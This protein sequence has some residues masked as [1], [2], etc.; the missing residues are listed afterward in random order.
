MSIGLAFVPARVCLAHRERASAMVVRSGVVVVL[1][2]APCLARTAN[3][4]LTFSLDTA[5]VRYFTNSNS[6]PGFVSVV[7]ATLGSSSIPNGI[8]LYGNGPEGASG[9][10]AFSLTGAQY[11]DGF[12]GIANTGTR[13]VASGL[14][15]GTL[16]PSEFVRGAFDIG[17]ALTGA[18]SSSVSVG[19]EVRLEFYV[20]DASGS[21]Y[22]TGFSMAQGLGGVSGGGATTLLLSFDTPTIG[23]QIGPMPVYTEA[24][25]SAELFF[26]WT[27]PQ[28]GDILTVDVPNHSIDYSIVPSPQTLV[29]GI[30]ALSMA[31][32]RR[33]RA[34]PVLA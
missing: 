22:I 15:T 12:N 10:R 11:N 18:T 7:P 3:A 26:F 20:T 1:A 17:V 24:R 5:D 30:G 23:S 4:Q 19:A 31:C 8:R 25:W 14:I 27:S 9:D 6:P 21:H 33:K 16:H 32:P 34:M 13:M 29:L 28:P 2:F